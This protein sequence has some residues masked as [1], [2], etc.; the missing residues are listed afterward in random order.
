MLILLQGCT[1]MKI[2]DYEGTTPA[3]VLE[4]YFLGN[5]TAWG[6]FQDRKGTVKRQF[7][8]DITGSLDEKGLKLIEDFR[9]RDGEESRRVWYIEKTGEHSYEGRAKDVVGT[10]TGTAYGNVLHWN[11]DL[12]LAVKDKIWKVHFDDWMFLQ[13]DGVLINRATMSKFGIK[14]GEVTIVFRKAV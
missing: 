12:Q 7:V 1:A 10:A 3:L 5:V 6:I 8:V 13:E 4:E 14:L 2:E 11:Y 9:Y